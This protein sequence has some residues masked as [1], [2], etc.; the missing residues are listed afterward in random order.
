MTGRGLGRRSFLK[1]AGTGLLAVPVVGA[2]GRVGLAAP[3]RIETKASV[4]PA[5]V[6]LNVREYGAL[7]D[8]VVKDTV[9][10]QQTIDRCWVFG[11]G[12][13]VIPAGSYLTGAIALRSNVLLRLEKDAVIIGSAEFA[14]YPVMQVRWEGKWIQGHVGLIYALDAE[15]TGIVGPG[16]IMGNHALGG[17]PN[18]TNPLRHPALIEPMGCRDLR[19]EEFSTDYYR[20]WSLHLTYCED[21]VVRNLTIRST[22]GNGDGIDVDSCKRVRID[23]CDIA[24]G[25]DCISVKSGRGSEAY[26]LLKT[27][28]DVHISNCTFADS[29]FACIGIGSETSGGIRN[30][31]VEKCKFIGAKTF[32]IYIK[33]RPGRGAFI[34][35]IVC[36]DLECSGMT[37]GFLRFNILASGIQDEFP[38]PG[39]EGIPTIRNFRFS[40]IKVTD[41]PVLVDGV[42]IHP[43]KPLEGF[44]LSDVTG[45]CAKGISLANVKHAV[46][47]DVKVTGYSGPLLSVSNVTGSGLNGATTIEAPKVGEDVV[48]P[49]KPYQL[50]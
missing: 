38:V 7:G 41:C 15:H 48:A 26:R 24:T 47:R 21:V 9:A 17:R 12:E 40:K 50:R 1:Q 13:V 42:G 29:I 43:R 33:S 39:D 35:D 2:M 46:I 20:M 44:T 3:K 10:I 8:G 4:A 36:E 45:T 19:F 34:E 18:V 25:D 5:K 37:G 27:S 6:V 22:G 23:G 14:D 11:G 31:R 30:V 28:E 49:E 16:K 32:A